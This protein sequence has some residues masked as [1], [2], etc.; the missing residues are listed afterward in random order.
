MKKRPGGRN[1]NV[2]GKSYAISIRI[3]NK[4][5]SSISFADKSLH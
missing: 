4:Y 3:L 1:E 5:P 2:T